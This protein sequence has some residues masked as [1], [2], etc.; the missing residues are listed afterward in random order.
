MV[1]TMLG[2]LLALGIML[3]AGLP[4]A[5]ADADDDPVR[6]ITVTGR[7]EAKAVPDIAVLSIGVETEAETPGKALADNAERMTDVMEK[8]KNAGIADRDLQTSQLGIWPVFA[9][10]RQASE[11]IGYRASNQ[12]SVTIRNIDRLGSIL[13]DAVADGANR[14]NGPTF[15]IADPEP[16]LITA[17]EAAVKDGIAK[18]ERYAAAAGVELGEVVSIDESRGSAAVPR[19]MRA[20]AMDVSTPIA[21]GETRLAAAVTM[22]FA[23][24]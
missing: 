4:A 23:I 13:D 1:R 8:L 15:S 17:R 12:L 22:I 10:R 7:A 24:D 19:H 6:T 11:V 21:A 18:A 5:S 20:E 2:S 9:E 14:V 16:L 3:G